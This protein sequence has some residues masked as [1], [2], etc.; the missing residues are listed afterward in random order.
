MFL[1]FVAIGKI[2]EEQIVLWVGLLLFYLF[3]KQS[4]FG[5]ILRKIERLFV[6]QDLGYFLLKCWDFLLHNWVPMILDGV[7]CSQ[8]KI[9]GHFGPFATMKQKQQIKHPLLFTSPFCFIDVG[10]EMIV[11][12]LT[13]LLTNPVRNELRNKGPS[14][15]S[16]LINR[17]NQDFIFLF[18]PLPF[19]EHQIPILISKPQSH[20]F[21]LLQMLIRSF[22]LSV[23]LFVYLRRWQL[24]REL[25]WW[26]C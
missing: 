18:S 3:E 11:P 6:R 15:G 23:V 16:M 5:R 13:T 26:H 21:H 2:I 25:H 12:S 14:F 17:F 19:P 20:K 22:R 24:L 1:W 10:I 8:S 7:V 9:I 4:F